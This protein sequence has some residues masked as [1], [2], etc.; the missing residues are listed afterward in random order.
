MYE[1]NER[2]FAAQGGQMK[3][4]KAILAAV[5]GLAAFS[6]AAEAQSRAQIERRYTP[7]YHQCMNA[8]S[9]N[10]DMTNCYGDELERQD[11]RLNQAYVMVMRP[12]SSTKKTT[13]RTLQ[14]TWLKQRDAKCD[15]ERNQYSG[16]SIS[17]GVFMGCMLDETIKRTI[18]LENYR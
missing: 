1:C 8:A 3:R 5:W 10:Y 6:S 9:T 15:R 11:G 7:A 13:L 2:L 4:S 14:R 18:Y 16:G 17:A 12:L